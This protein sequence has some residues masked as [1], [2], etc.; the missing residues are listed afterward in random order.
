MSA[1]RQRR[2]EGPPN[3]GRTTY[4]HA[5]SIL[6]ALRLCVRLPRPRFSPACG[7][8]LCLRTA[9]AM[10]V[11]PKGI[12]LPMTASAQL[13]SANFYLPTPFLKNGRRSSCITGEFRRIPA[14]FFY[15]PIGVGAWFLPSIQL[16]WRSGSAGG[17]WMLVLGAFSIRIMHLSRRSAAKA[18]H[19]VPIIGALYVCR[20]NFCGFAW[21]CVSKNIL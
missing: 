8:R 19:L 3:R 4:V 14:S 5:S 12:R 10:S 7:A 9:T 15:R 21:F 11:S 17:A 18:D 13:L 2:S 1:Q 16:S 20:A 6:A